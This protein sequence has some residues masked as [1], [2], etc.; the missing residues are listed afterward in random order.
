MNSSSDYIFKS[1]REMIK[2]AMDVDGP[3]NPLQLENA[4]FDATHQHVHG[5]KSLGLWIYH[6]SMRKILRLA[7]MEIRTENT[8]DITK[9]FLFFNE[10]M[11]KHTGKIGIKFNPRCFVHDESGANYAAI[12]VVY[13]ENFCKNHIKGCQWHFKNDVNKKANDVTPEYRELF[14]SMCMK[15]CHV[16]TVAKY[17]ILKSK[18]DEIAKMSPRIVKWI[19]WW[20]QRRS[21]IFGPFHY[22]GLPGVNLAEQG[23]S[24]WK[25][26]KPLRLVHAAKSDTAT[27]IL[28]GEE[29]YDFTR[30]L[31]KSS[32]RGPS[33]AVRMARDKSEQIGIG[34]DFVNIFD[35][36][37]AVLEEAHE[38]NNPSSYQPKS[39]SYLNLMK[40]RRLKKISQQKKSQKKGQ[41]RNVPTHDAEGSDEHIRTKINKASEIILGRKENI[42]VKKKSRSIG[43]NPPT[44]IFTNGLGIQKCQGCSKEITRKDQVYP[45]NMVFRRKALVENFNKK[46]NKYIYTNNNIHIHL[47]KKCLRDQDRTVEYR[48]IIA[49]D[50]V[51]EA[52]TN[53]QMEVLH[54]RDILQYIIENKRKHFVSNGI[55]WDLFFSLHF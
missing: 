16:T 14:K 11:E 36:I 21:H 30:N 15:L 52:L 37:E 6:P 23:N 25:C 53:E 54:E 35:D 4:Y 41:K 45:R 49:T 2:L 18:L 39:R 32:G 46:V 55:F 28:Q 8:E 13:G 51:F 29:L 34:V 42:Q 1:S 26:K 17:T 10:I 43:S 19:D 50:E 31:T 22:P 3:E 44:L 38:V 20:H 12:S 24:S 33:P 9:F 5:F 7:S 48:D 27:M 47:V 40:Q